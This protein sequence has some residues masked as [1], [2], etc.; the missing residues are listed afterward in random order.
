MVGRVIQTSQA[1][2][3]GSC[4]DLAHQKYGDLHAILAALLSEG[5]IVAFSGG[6]D[7]AFLLWAARQQQRTG[8]GRLLALTAV[9]PSMA[10]I[11]RDDARAFAAQLDV[12]HVWHESHELENPA[13]ALND[14]R[15]CYHCKNELFRI[16]R[17]VATGTSRATDGYRW[18]AYG[19]SASD[20]HDVRPGHE[21]ATEHGVRSP[22]AEAGLEKEEI[23]AL[24]RHHGVDL[25]DKPASP[26]LSSRLMR[27]VRVTPDRLRD[28][29]QLESLLRA[30][31]LRVFRVRV[32]EV[33]A[34]SLLRVEAAPEELRL[35]F[36]VREE[37]A[38]AGEA[39]GYD[40]VT[41]DLAGYRVGGGAR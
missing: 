19:Y 37:L 2:V 34:R 15:R 20:R 4:P 12:D 13:Y 24:M 14:A 31:G 9:S 10:Q 36:E 25:A 6:V 30:R 16:C 21:A 23:R 5:L 38:S 3:R 18:L 7:S 28:V 32:H 8:G 17:D 39:R 11:E 41:L 1:A 27:G 33:G 40:W 29:E 22:L 35:A 26:C